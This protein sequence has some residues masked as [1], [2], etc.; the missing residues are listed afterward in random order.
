MGKYFSDI[1]DQALEDIYYCYDGARAARVIEPL[2]AASDAG[3]GDASYILSRCFS[4]PQYS[5]KYHPYQDNDDLAEEYVRKSIRQGSAMGVLGAMRCGM[6]T[7]EMKAVMHF[8]TLQEA[9]DVVHQKAQDGCLF[10]QNMIGNT[11][12]WLDVVEIQDK[13][14][15]SFP[16]REAFIQYLRES[17]LACIPWFEKA[18]RGGMGFAGRNLY[19]LYDSGEE[20]LVEPQPEKA[21]E[22][23]KLGAELGYPDWMET[24][25]IALLK[26]PGR[27][28][29]GL[30]YCEGAAGKGQLSAWYQVGF[31]YQQGTIVQKDCV[32]ALSCYEKGLADPEKS[33]S[34]CKAG[35]LYFLGQDG[36]PQDYEK[37]VQLF[38]HAHTYNKNNWGNDMLGICYLFGRGCKQDPVKARALFEEADYSS[39]LKN[40]GLGMIYTE[41]MGIAANIKK[42][43]EYLQKAKDYAPAQEALLH[44]KKNLFGKWVKK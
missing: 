25:G 30:G 32:H 16:N 5:W 42:G 26:Q 43:V 14:I 15:N 17:T 39:D 34:Y 21:A 40:Y 10:C 6:L 37:A 31:A 24:Y 28:L 41:G 13:S 27:E 23:Q 18:F 11:Y 20:D 19:N 9:W 38:E 1:V 36:V 7:P 29:E 33:G 22:V 3:D 2:K 35:E 4:G 12:F 44:Y 8:Q